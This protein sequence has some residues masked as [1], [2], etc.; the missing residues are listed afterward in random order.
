MSAADDQDPAATGQQLMRSVMREGLFP[1]VRTDPTV[2]RAFLRGFNLL[3]APE[4]LLQDAEVMA[5]V[6]E[7]Y[8]S[9]D[10]RLPEP[11][12]GPDRT[13]LLARLNVA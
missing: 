5:R 6:M 12:L 7:A 13:E 2:F 3:E 9:R 11:P 4:V 10:Q 1:A 8:Q